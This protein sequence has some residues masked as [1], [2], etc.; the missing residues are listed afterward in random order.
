MAQ[1][2][3]PYACKLLFQV[4]QKGKVK[5]VLF[6]THINCFLGIDLDYKPKF[7]K[8]RLGAR[9][10]LNASLSPYAPGKALVLLVAESVGAVDAL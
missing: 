3:M 10:W 7:K 1:V 6:L 8:A 2:R 9:R 4:L 5:M